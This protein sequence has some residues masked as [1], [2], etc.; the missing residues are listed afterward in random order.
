MDRPGSEQSVIFAGQLVPPRNMGDDHAFQLFDEAVAGSYSARVNLNLREDKHW[1]YGA[2][3]LLIDAVGQRP[4]AVYAPVQTDR[5]KEALQEVVKEMV[6][7]TS[8]RPVSAEELEEA[9]RRLIQSLA[10][11]W[12]TAGS[13]AGALLEIDRYGLPGDYYSTF[14]TDLNAVDTAAVARVSQAIIQPTRQ[15]IVVVGDRE[16][17]EAGIREL[18]LGPL[19]VL[20]PDG[21]PLQAAV[22][23]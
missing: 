16:K 6:D 3:S 23:P 5:T 7:A 13:V 19:E 1:S 22:T 8:A 14:A 21:K 4:W 15:V 11:R 9:K 20:G 12:E 17:I 2:Y 18:N 10:G